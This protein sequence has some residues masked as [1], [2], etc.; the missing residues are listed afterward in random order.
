MSLVTGMLGVA[1]ACGC[2]VLG[3]CGGRPVIPQSD[4]DINVPPTPMNADCVAACEAVRQKLI[5]SF[6]VPP[7]DVDCLDAKWR[8]AKDT[9]ACC[10]VF[11][12]D[13]GVQATGVCR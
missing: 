3:G 5:T 2:V 13:Y 8:Y 11:R 7:E 9:A 1:A 6:G 12:S 4:A 10:D